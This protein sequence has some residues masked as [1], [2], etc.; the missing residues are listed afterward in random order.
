MSNK[1]I[2]AFS[3]KILFGAALVA[4]TV[5]TPA[6][7]TLEVPGIELYYMSGFPESN[8]DQARV[9]LLD[10]RFRKYLAQYGYSLAPPLNEPDVKVQVAS[11]YLFHHSDVAA[12]LARQAGAGWMVLAHLVQPTSLWAEFNV[13]LVEAAT[14]RIRA[15]YDVELKGPVNDGKD[16]DR[17]AERMV[18]KLDSFL[19]RFAKLQENS[20]SVSAKDD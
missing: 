14:G 12:A 15:D 20:K 16:T 10:A 4:A 19:Q 6:A 2:R 8:V 9:R 18:Q 17:A 1:A 5:A 11:G 13:Q 7:A 3:I